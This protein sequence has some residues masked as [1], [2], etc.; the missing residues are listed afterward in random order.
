MTA[1]SVGHDEQD[2]LLAHLDPADAAL[3]SA[4]SKRQ[5]SDHEGVLVLFTH[6]ADIAAGSNGDMNPRDER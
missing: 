4:T 6:S 3:G 2:A 1:H 5:I